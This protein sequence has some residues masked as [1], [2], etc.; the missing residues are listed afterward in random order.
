MTKEATLYTKKINFKITIKKGIKREL[1]SVGNWCLRNEAWHPSSD[2]LISFP[3]NLQSRTT[4]HE[5]TIIKV[6]EFPQLKI[7]KSPVD[8]ELQNLQSPKQ[9]IQKSMLY[10][11]RK[12][13]K[14]ELPNNNLYSYESSKSHASVQIKS[15]LN[16]PFFFL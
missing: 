13:K 3:T 16:T 11:H 6:L 1:H 12:K 14:P 15:P 2:T 4:T 5:P 9:P 8:L 10:I 7:K